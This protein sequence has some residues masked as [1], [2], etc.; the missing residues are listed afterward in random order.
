MEVGSR[1]MRLEFGIGTYTYM[2]TERGASEEEGKRSG[3]FTFYLEGQVTSIYDAD[4]EWIFLSLHFEG[5]S[6]QAECELSSRLDKSACRRI[7]ACK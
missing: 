4:Q 7:P 5:N 2:C 1:R 6:K 3:F